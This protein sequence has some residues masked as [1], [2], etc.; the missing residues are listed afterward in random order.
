MMNNTQTGYV[1]IYSPADAGITHTV[2]VPA[3][4]KQQWEKIKKDSV[5]NYYMTSLVRAV[6]R[7]AVGDKTVNSQA[8]IGDFKFTYKVSSDRKNIYINLIELTESKSKTDQSPGLY[9]AKWRGGKWF[10]PSEQYT[11]MDLNHKWSHGA[12]MAVVPGK[13][14]SKEYAGEMIGTHVEKAYFSGNTA[15]NN[16]RK[17]GNHFSLFWSNNEFTSKQHKDS[18]V[19]LIQTA[20]KQS[21]SVQWLVHG[22]GA[23]M[24]VEAM[25]FIKNNPKSS[26]LFAAQKGLSTQEVYFSN[27]RGRHSSKK[28]LEEIC[29]SI[30]MNCAGV[31]IN[32]KDVLYN[33]DA[34]KGMLNE[35]AMVAGG[36]AFAG[37]GAA[38]LSEEMGVDA[39]MKV[40]DLAMTAPGLASMLALAGG[41]IVVAGKGASISGYVRNMH[42]T[43]SSTFGSGNQNWAA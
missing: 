2:H 7:L 14:E 32:T 27:P 13:F 41:I 1:V 21:A 43:I 29:K 23:A 3:Q 20:Q 19:S 35:I 11:T 39:L 34:R 12:H 18:L 37:G 6:L 15:T 9:Q 8:V 33:A 36:V 30:G 16:V 31:N 40:K 26:E 42:G 10:V 17:G 4:Q 28:S 25:K 22:E 24:F 5:G 38:G